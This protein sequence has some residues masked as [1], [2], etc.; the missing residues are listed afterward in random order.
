VF[1]EFIF[2]LPLFFG[3]L[4]RKINQREAIDKVYK[5]CERCYVHRYVH[6]RQAREMGVGK[7][8]SILNEM[9]WKDLEKFIIENKTPYNR[10][11]SVRRIE[12]M[13]GLNRETI[14]KNVIKST[15][16]IF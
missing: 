5:M 6:E 10:P 7:F 14:R 16:P 4:K 9:S 15:K 11:F 1:L 2:I 3:T 12:R 13:S 8:I